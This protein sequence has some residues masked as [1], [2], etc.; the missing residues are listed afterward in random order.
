MLIAP[1][2]PAR[3]A[4]K[5]VPKVLDNN[6]FVKNIYKGNPSPELDQAWEDL[7]EGKLTVSTHASLLLMSMSRHEHTS[8]ERHIGQPQQD[9][10]SSAGRFWRLLGEL[11][12]VPQLTLLGQ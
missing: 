5:L 7:V 1:T 9:I 3:E 10:N 4:I 12:R 11:W 8:L 2:A 6:L